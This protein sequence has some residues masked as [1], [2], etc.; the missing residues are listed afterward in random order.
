MK[1]ARSLLL[2]L[3]S[4]S[5]VA[6][7][8]YHLYDKNQYSRRIREVYIKDSIAVA[9]AVSDSL[10]KIFTRTLDQLAAEKLSIDSANTSLKGELGNRL[11]EINRMKDEISVILRRKNLKQADLDEAKAKIKEL[12][13]VINSMQGENTVLAEEKVRLNNLLTQLTTEMTALQLTMNKVTAENKVLV[14]T[15][16]EASTFIASELSL[17]AMYLKSNEREEKTN[18]VKKADK[19]VAS[20]AVQNNVASFSNT[21]VVI[22][23]TDPLGK[24]MTGDVW[25]SGSFETRE[26]RKNF[27][28]KMRFEYNKNESK[29]LIFSIQP[30]KFEKGV[31]KLNLYHN[32]VMIG[33]TEWKLG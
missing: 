9:E 30:E 27:T 25:D 15:L 6:T 22:V 4:V 18:Q 8:I 10:R 7:W 1:D 2:A 24:T 14:Q 3:L 12:Q 5:L 28:R 20:F 23:I 19:F 29:K 26:G 13:G 33:E 32:G 16:T 11:R 31:Y 21:E 17:T